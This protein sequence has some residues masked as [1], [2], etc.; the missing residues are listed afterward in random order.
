MNK[1]KEELTKKAVDKMWET[2]HPNP[3]TRLFDSINIST[4][5]SISDQLEKIEESIS[6]IR[7]ET[8]LIRMMV[9]ALLEKM[10]NG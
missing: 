9:Q 3:K 8:S 4:G 10:N 5:P 1:D 2:E 6:E 7:Q